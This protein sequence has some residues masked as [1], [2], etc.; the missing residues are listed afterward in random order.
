MVITIIFIIFYP[1]FYPQYILKEVP[2]FAVYSVGSPSAPF[3]FCMNETRN[4]QQIY[5]GAVY[6]ST[7]RKSYVFFVFFK[8]LKHKRY[9]YI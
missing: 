7:Y 9:H 2:S 4:P 1:Q 3:E 8:F 5:H 6:R